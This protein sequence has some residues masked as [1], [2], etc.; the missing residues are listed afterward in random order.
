MTNSSDNNGHGSASDGPRW[1]L[2]LIRSIGSRAKFFER[3]IELRR[4][5][6][7]GAA[8]ADLMSEQEVC[9]RGWAL[10][11][12]LR[13][14]DF[15]RSGGAAE[16]AYDLYELAA[17][18]LGELSGATA[19]ALGVAGGNEWEQ[20]LPGQMPAEALQITLM[21]YCFP[22]QPPILMISIAAGS[23]SGSPGVAPEPKGA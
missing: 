2:D 23:G 13:P 17:A 1:S 12:A 4:L 22:G 5:L 3:A 8:A 16:Q 11:Q 15:V 10:V 6:A 19:A 18:R 7:A 21:L 9:K 14:A 20:F